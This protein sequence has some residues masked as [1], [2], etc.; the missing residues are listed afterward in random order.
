MA[1]PL[2]VLTI[3]IWNRQGRWEDR[4]RLL[5]KG[6]ADLDPDVIGV[7]EVIHRPSA[8]RTHCQ[9]RALA[10]A[11][12]AAGGPRDLSVS[13]GPAFTYEDG[14]QFGNAIVSR[15][16]LSD[17]RTFALPGADARSLH[18]A[19]VSAPS[20]PVPFFVTHLS[21]KFDEGYLREGQVLGIA[22]ALPRV[23]AE[24]DLPAVL[25]GDLNAAPDTTE[26][27]F[28][29]GKHALAGRSV[30]FTDCFERA[31]D[32]PGFTF[33]PRHNPHAA[34]TFEAPRRIDYVLCQGPDD[35]GRGLP[36]SARVVLDGV[37]EGG[38][39]APSD[40]YGVLSELRME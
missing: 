33:D 13:F 36:V 21:W 20:G 24:G 18:F 15:F 1:R 17:V 30:F 14:D 27:R 35:R 26:I 5:Q 37:V 38:R 31:G 2:R 25:V 7:Q 16:P 29:A 11:W 23:L 10:D 4:L 9:A 40:H 34:L 32:G 3:N 39:L 6:I 28:L 12:T 8:P 19:R 22:D